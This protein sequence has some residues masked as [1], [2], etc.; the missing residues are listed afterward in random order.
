[1]DWMNCEKEKKPPL[2]LYF[3][4][5]LY[6]I[7]SSNWFLKLEYASFKLFRTIKAPSN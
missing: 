3:Y 4:N 7:V 5:Q 2:I 1:M 6:K